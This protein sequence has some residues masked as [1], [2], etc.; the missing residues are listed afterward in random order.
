M[1]GFPSTARSEAR[2][3]SSTAETGPPERSCVARAA[4]PMSGKNASA[5]ALCGCSIT[6]R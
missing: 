5:L 3:M 6:V 1:P 4:S 2:S